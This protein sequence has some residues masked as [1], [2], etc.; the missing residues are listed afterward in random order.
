MPFDRLTIEEADVACKRVLIRVDFDVS[1]E[2]GQVANTEK[3]VA[4]VPTIQF[5]LEAGAKYVVVA[6]HMGSPNGQKNC[7]LSLRPVAAALQKELGKEVTFLPDCVG[8]EVEAALCKATKGQVF[9][10]ENLRFHIEEE[11]C[12]CDKCGHQISAKPEEVNCFK[13]Q[14]K[15]L[16]D[17]YVNDAL[18]VSASPAASVTNTCF[19]IRAAG[20][21][22]QKDIE[23][24]SKMTEC[25]EK[26]MVLIVGGKLLAEKVP[27][28]LKMIEVVDELIVTGGPALTFLKA[29]CGIDIGCSEFDENGAASV[30]CILDKAA[31]S[32]VPVTLPDDLVVANQMSDSADI[33]EM[34]VQDGVPDGFMALDV[35]VRSRKAA[36]CVLE[37]A[38]TIL[39]TGVPGMFEMDKFSCGSRCMMKSVAEA[40]KRGA[41]TAVI[42]HATTALVKSMN[43]Q[44]DVSFMSMD[45]G[46]AMSFLGGKQL[47]GVEALS[48]KNNN[49]C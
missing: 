37:R 30:Q 25:P 2:C 11:G 28:I 44:E 40:T 24:L 48:P 8:V 15:K 19:Q 36:K 20:C 33:C 21:S 23:M 35:G 42:G 31:S 32:Q 6:S 26:P 9:L 7:A 39:W 18:S 10:L 13:S 46:A 22:L 5:A 29:S 45:G 4:S 16:A 49:G 38:G 17:I 47:P 34:K 43:M 41:F 1:I 27:F 12:G 3:I 14:L